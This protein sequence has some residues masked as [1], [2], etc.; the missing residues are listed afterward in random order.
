MN[1][2]FIHF[3]DFYPRLI[4]TRLTASLPMVGGGSSMV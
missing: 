2:S 3:P 1:A 4:E